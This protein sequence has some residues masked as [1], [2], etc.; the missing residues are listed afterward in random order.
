MHQYGGV[1]MNKLNLFAGAAVAALLTACG[2]SEETKQSVITGDTGKSDIKAEL[3]IWSWDVAA[4]GLED[5]IPSFNK[6]FPNVKVV[7]EEFGTGDTY[8][9]LMIGLNSNT[10]LPDIMTIE[11]DNFVRY[12][13]NFPGGFYDLT[14]VAAGMKADFDPSKWPDGKYEGRLYALPWDSAPAGLFFRRDF[15]QNAG[16]DANEL[17][18]WD[19]FIIAGQ[20]VQDANPGVKMIP[21]NYAKGTYIHHMLTNQL[22]GGKFNEVGEITLSDRNNIKAMKLQKRMLDED[23]TYNADSWNTLVIATKNNEVATVPYG[24]WWGG[25]LKDQMPEQSGKWGFIPFPAFEEGGS[26][27]S[28]AGGASLAIPS[29]SDNGEL[30]WAFIQNAIATKENAVMM[31]KKY[32]LFP[33][34]LPAFEDPYFDEGDVYFAG[35]NV[36][37]ELADM[38]PHIQPSFK[39]E[40]DSEASDF[41]LTAQSAILLEDAPVQESLER[42][43]NSVSTATGRTIAR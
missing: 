37:R 17:N 27:A 32:D 33:S 9:K 22:G 2:G 1:L 18:T 7:V 19:E 42:A 5:T 30:A 3:K 39:T 41:L 28:Y 8:Q 31:Y 36:S 24:G 21:V 40:D 43:A 20:K 14:E 29:Q 13:P 11:T 12:P 6:K 16:V 35:Q 15:F 34:Y 25:T 23:L 10:G 38:V 4:K 26:R